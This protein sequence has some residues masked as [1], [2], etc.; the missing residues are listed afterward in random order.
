M[1]WLR[2]PNPGVDYMS[3]KNEGIKY[4]DFLTHVMYVRHV[5][6]VGHV[7]HGGPEKIWGCVV[8][9]H[10]RAA[11]RIFPHLDLRFNHFWTLR[12]KNIRFKN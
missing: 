2:K 7:R 12:F 11:D 8:W 4:E 10:C 6:H 9:L 5:G 3:S 1:G